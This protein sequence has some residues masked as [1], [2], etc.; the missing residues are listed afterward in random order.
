[1]RPYR[2][3]IVSGMS[4]NSHPIRMPGW[5]GMTATR[6]CASLTPGFKPRLRLGLTCFACH[7]T[8]NTDNTAKTASH[9][10]H[11]IATTSY[12]AY[13]L[14]SKQACRMVTRRGQGESQGR[15]E[16]RGRRSY[17]TTSDKI[18]HFSSKIRHA[19]RGTSHYQD[20]ADWSAQR[21]YNHHTSPDTTHIHCRSYHRCQ[22]RWL[23]WS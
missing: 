13:A 4:C 2:R 16:G 17:D 9:A 11:V 12:R 15:R 7:R 19:T 10:S 3:G 1:M 22:A 8:N 21:C 20:R 14:R 6:G 18:V 23:A 5:W